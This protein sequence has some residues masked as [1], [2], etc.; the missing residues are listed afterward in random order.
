MPALNRIG[1]GLAIVP[2]TIA[3]AAA[4]PAFGHAELGLDAS[5]ANRCNNL[6][7]VQVGMVAALVTVGNAK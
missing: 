5:A 4:L 2:V 7:A 3:Q 6:R 1:R